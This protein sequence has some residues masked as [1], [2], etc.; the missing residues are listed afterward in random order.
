[1]PRKYKIAVLPGD[2]IGRE[3]IPE[4]LK[5]MKKTAS[6]L[7]GIDLD[8]KEFECGGEYFLNNDRE[9]SEDTETYAKTK[10]DAILLGAMGAL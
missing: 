5:V 4:A 9:W 2:G 6:T 8:T 1:M 3:V 7:G 10:A